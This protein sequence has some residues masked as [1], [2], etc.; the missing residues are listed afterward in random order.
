MRQSP[1]EGQP[2]FTQALHPVSPESFACWAVVFW[3]GGLELHT[4]GKDGIALEHFVLFQALS[5]G[6]ETTL[7][8]LV[9][10]FQCR[11]CYD[12]PQ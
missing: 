4:L 11:C 1:S 8:F 12:L 7:A 5:F 10:H 9:L 2:A 3:N 6:I